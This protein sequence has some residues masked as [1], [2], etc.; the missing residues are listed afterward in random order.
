[1]AEQAPNFTPIVTERIS[2]VRAMLD[3]G[4]TDAEIAAALGIELAAVAQLPEVRDS[5][6]NAAM[7]A[8]A[9]RALYSCVRGQTVIE[10]K[11]DRFGDVH[12]LRKQ[13]PPDPRAAMAWLERRKPD[14]WA[15]KTPQVR[16]VLILREF[17][18][19]P[20]DADVIE[21]KA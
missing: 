21:H 13:L 9:V 15:D 19:T 16:P 2:P 10:E 12:Q 20:R 7:N 4:A 17:P 1:M 6:P 14:E 5:E 8:L 3:A 11:L 18:D